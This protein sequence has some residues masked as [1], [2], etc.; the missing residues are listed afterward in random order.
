MWSNT[1]VKE[2]VGLFAGGRLYAGELTGREIRS[3]MRYTS[4]LIAKVG[5]TA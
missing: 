1:G 4:C 3:E 2:K 5:D